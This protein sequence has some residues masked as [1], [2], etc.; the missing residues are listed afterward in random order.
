MLAIC[1]KLSHSVCGEPSIMHFIKEA[2]H[3][4]LCHKL[5]DAM[6]FGKER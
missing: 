6:W 5:S 2:L 4:S 1:Y 3:T